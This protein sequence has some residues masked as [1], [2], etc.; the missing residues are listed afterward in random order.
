MLEDHGVYVAVWNP[1][2][3]LMNGNFWIALPMAWWA[4]GFDFCFVYWRL[5]RVTYSLSLL[6]GLTV[7]RYFLRGFG[8]FSL[9]QLEWI[10]RW[11]SI[12]PAKRIPFPEWNMVLVDNLVVLLWRWF[13]PS[14]TILLILHVSKPNTNIRP[15]KFL[16]L[17]IRPEYFWS[18]QPTRLLGDRHLSKLLGV[19]FPQ[20][21]T[22]SDWS[23]PKLH[24]LCLVTSAQIIFSNL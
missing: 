6:L 13:L 23:I 3:D 16:R 14:S 22:G 11:K 1:G 12:R 18:P 24:R 10:K 9:M 17:G 7:S 15:Q 2:W 4:A 21:S 20:I 8:I 19:L 5:F